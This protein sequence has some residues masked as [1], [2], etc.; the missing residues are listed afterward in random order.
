M[1][2]LAGLCP[3]GALPDKDPPGQRPPKQRPP[4][5]GET[6]LDRPPPRQRPLPLYGK[7]RAVRIL[8]ESTLVSYCLLEM[9]A[10]Q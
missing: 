9:K 6:P 10:M 5:N 4:P 1:F 2:L 7:E 8:L 3:E